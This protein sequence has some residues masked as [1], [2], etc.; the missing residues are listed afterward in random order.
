MMAYIACLDENNKVI[1]IIIAESVE[2][3]KEITGFNCIEYTEESP[4]GVG[5]TWDGTKFTAPATE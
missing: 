1:N 5:Y 2:F 3:A 4:A